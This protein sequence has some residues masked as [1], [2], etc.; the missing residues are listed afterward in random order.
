[1]NVRKYPSYP[2]WSVILTVLALFC[3]APT[4]L[5]QEVEPNN[6]C[7]TATNLGPVALPISMSGE[8]TPPAPDAAGDV[9]FYR[10]QAAARTTVEV[11]LQ[12]ESSEN[13]TLHDPVLG[14]FNGDCVLIAS[15]DDHV[16]LDSRLAFS[17]PDNGHFVLA[18]TSYPD[19]SFNGSHSADGT[20]LLTLSAF[21]AIG[22]VYGRVVDAETGN[23]PED[24][25]AVDL[26]RCDDPADPQ[27]CSHLAA[28][29]DTSDGEFRITRDRYGSLLPTG[30]YLVRA[31]TYPY[32]FEGRS[33]QF[34]VAENEDYEVATIEIAVPPSIGSI[35]GRIIDTR[36]GL[37]LSGAESPFA[38]V[39]L[40]RCEEAECN[41]VDYT[42]ADNEGYFSFIPAY[43]GALEAGD[44]MVFAHALEYISSEGTAVPAIAEDEDR[45]IGDIAL[46]PHPIQ[47]AM[48]RSC[49]NL[50]ATGGPCRYRVRVTNRSD[51]QV[52]GTAWSIVSGTTGT[53]SEST[54]FQTGNPIPMV[55]RPGATRMLEFRFWVPP[56][57]PE[58]GY[59]CATTRFGKG[60]AQPYFKT[61]A[62]T[63]FCIDRD[64]TGFSSAPKNEARKMLRGQDRILEES[65]HLKRN[66]EVERPRSAR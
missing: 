45:E 31:Y 15:N 63:Y 62:Q 34:V 2:M 22:S 6:T 4:I 13:G 10:F 44:Y 59:L 49:P 18:A 1:M 33:A 37:G 57:V 14:L 52:V 58:E 46:T 36:T 3:T 12:G 38:Y 24:E 27:T 42:D 30:S 50:P 25:A 26:Y 28:Y 21:P 61:L 8:L 65:R 17:I 53:L 43:Q 64:M 60:L 66:S 39:D 55:L 29:A 23:P 11:N 16:N 40:Y 7:E 35:S 32:G 54:V 9:D 56:T 5:A 20:Y 51:K 47:L 48:V 41:Y 19:G